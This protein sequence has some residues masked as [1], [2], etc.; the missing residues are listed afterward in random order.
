MIV[1]MKEVLLLSSY[2]GVSQVRS[3]IPCTG[4]GEMSASQ[5][6][7]AAGWAP[8]ADAMRSPSAWESDV[9]VG[10]GA[11]QF[12][13]CPESVGFGGCLAGLADEAPPFSLIFWRE[14]KGSHAKSEYKHSWRYLSPVANPRCIQALLE[15]HKALT[16]NARNVT[17]Q[18]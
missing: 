13:D 12:L 5:G 6:L 18:T 15:I 8:G 14:G 11:E 9:A 1:K 3:G 2:S 10:V 17:H 7:A 4:F 16:S